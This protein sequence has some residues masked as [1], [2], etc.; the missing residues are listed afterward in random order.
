LQA[1]ER[2]QAAAA[3]PVLQS[4]VLALSQAAAVAAFR[5]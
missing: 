4:Q 2:S 1:R 3:F 5:V